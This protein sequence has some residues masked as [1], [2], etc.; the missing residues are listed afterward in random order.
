MSAMIVLAAMVAWYAALGPLAF[1]MGT[2]IGRRVQSVDRCKAEIVLAADEENDRYLFAR[3]RWEEQ[4]FPSYWEWY[5][6]PW[7]VY[8]YQRDN[9]A[10]RIALVWTRG[11]RE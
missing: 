3:L 9:T 6:K 11:R 8:A 2:W 5:A 4:S 7:R 10:W 1:G